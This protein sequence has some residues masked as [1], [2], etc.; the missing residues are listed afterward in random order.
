MESEDIR[1]VVDVW[2]EEYAGLSRLPFVS[3]VQIFENK[4]RTMGC[5]NPHP[6]GQIWAQRSVPVEPSKETKR[7][8]Q[9]HRTNRRCLLCDYLKVELKE[10]VRLV[11][12]NDG[13]VA[14]VP[15]WAVWPFEILVMSRRHVN[16]IVA[17]NDGERNTLADIMKQ[18][19]VRYDNLFRISFPYSSGIHQA[20]TDGVRHPEWH[21]HLHFLPPL[22]RSATI[23]KYMVGY[24]MLGNP[25]RDTA[26][27]SSA[28]RLRKLKPIHYKEAL[29]DGSS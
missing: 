8:R 3:Y 27:E 21:I 11:C 5:S 17:L 19:T 6:H 22:L 15:F 12:E 25:Q 14:V 18:V 2:A 20:P 26:P 23:R 9:Y 13:F 24:E 10:K 28:E 7:M 4:G 16:N 29:V 1:R